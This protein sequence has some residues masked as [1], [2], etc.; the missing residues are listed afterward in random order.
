MKKVLAVAAWACVCVALVSAQRLPVGNATRNFVKV[1]ADVVAITH[2]RVID[3]T[4][5]PARADQTLILKD[6]NI[7]AMGPSAST[8]T[9]PSPRC[10]RL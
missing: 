1:N 8:P 4:G 5:A 2:V 3:G 6:G 9:A 7:S 10:C